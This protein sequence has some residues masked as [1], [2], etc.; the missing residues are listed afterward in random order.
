M[1]LARGLRPDFYMNSIVESQRRL[2]PPQRYHLKKALLK[3]L[4]CPACL[5]AEEGLDVRVFREDKG[6][7]D[8]ADLT[9]PRCG[10]RYPVKNGIADLLP[11]GTRPT[12]EGA[13][14]ETDAVLSSYLWSHFSDL[15]ED[16]EASTAYGEWAGLM[17]PP[18]GPVLDIGAAV[19]RFAF[20]MSRKSDLVVGIDASHSF[21]R[22][23][24]RLMADRG[25]TLR[26][27]EEGHLSR[28]V[29]LKLPREWEMEKVEFLVADARALPFRRH[30]FSSVASLNLVDKVPKPLKHLLE[31]NRVA[32]ERSARFL[33]SDPFSWSARVAPEAEWLGGTEEG[34]FAGHGRENIGTLLRGQNGILMP[35]WDIEEEGHVWWKIRTHANHYELIRS[36]FIKAAR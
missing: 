22:T 31:G 9:C 24:R 23:A 20:E 34:P 21:V 1:S 6:D 26:L 13:R 25:M 18:G 8:S 11:P 3:M 28:R 16:P 36:C 15:L 30:A 10:R 2:Y 12:R 14:Y 33:I 7:I 19:G 4:I 17:P 35:P 5:P 32:G 29:S 27:V